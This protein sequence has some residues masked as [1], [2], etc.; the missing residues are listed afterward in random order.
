MGRKKTKEKSPAEIQTERVTTALEETD[1]T[2]RAPVFVRE[3]PGRFLRDMYEV[4]HRQGGKVGGRPRNSIRKMRET[5]LVGRHA[6]PSLHPKLMGRV[7]M[8]RSDVRALLDLFLGRWRWAE[9]HDP[10]SSITK[11]G[12]VGFGVIDRKRLRALLFSSLIKNNERSAS[13]SLP[14]QSNGR[15]GLEETQRRFGDVEISLHECDA[16]ITLSR[17]KIAV[18]PSSP[19]TINNIWHFLNDLYEHDRREK[20]HDRMLIWVIDMG[21]R[22]VEQPEAFEEYFNAGLLALQ[23]ASFANF[24]SRKNEEAVNRSSL[25]PPLRVSVSAGR[26]ERWQWLSERTVIVAQNLRLEEFDRLYSDE[27]ETLSKIR[28][29]DIGVTGEH[30]LP[31][32]TPR[33]WGRELRHLYGKEISAS[34]A[35]F[36]VFMRNEPWRTGEEIRTIRYF[37]HKP[38][39]RGR[40]NKISLSLQTEWATQSEEL[41]VPDQNYDHAFRLIYWAARHRLGRNGEETVNM[42]WDALAYLKKIGFRVLD[43]PL[44]MRIF[45]GYR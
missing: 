26:S 43:L 24:D 12:Y 41:R 42:G 15:V 18:G 13:L 22:E 39:P 35:T 27:E 19:Q 34:D 9:G 36:T 28:L 31:S 6:V 2:G 25:L 16:L 8:T 40:Q 11:D 33:A 38:L 32:T 4:W 14:E 10:L 21:T 30:V 23:L 1:R 29:K 5:W 45:L 3:D 20:I 44:F 17:H 37:A 7:K